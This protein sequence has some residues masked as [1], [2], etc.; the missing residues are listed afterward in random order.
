MTT[1][2]APV[3]DENVVVAAK[4]RRQAGELFEALKG[5]PERLA[6]NDAADKG[7]V[8]KPVGLPPELGR[9]L[10]KV[11]EVMARGGTVTIG[12]M[13]DE[14]STTVAA[15]HLGISRPTLMKLIRSGEIPAHKV[16]SHHRLNASD[17]LAFKKARLKSQRAAFEELREL[18]DQLEEL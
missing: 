12:S 10:A 3:H 15:T 7:D 6:V 9:V 16:G 14:L 17:V 1:T 13:P 18:E 5:H 8:N 11:I 4:E 2:L